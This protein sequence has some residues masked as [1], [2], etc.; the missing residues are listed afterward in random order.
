MR[1][2]ITDDTSISRK[3]LQAVF[4][5]LANDRKLEILGYVAGREEVT[6]SE[7]K[8]ELG[9][10]HTTAHEYCR[11]LHATGF[12]VRKGGKPARYAPA[13]FDLQ[14]SLSSI[15]DAVESESETLEYTIETYGEGSIDDVID[16]WERVEAGELTYREASEEV[17]M[18]HVDFLR[19]AQEL[20]LLTR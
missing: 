11:D 2:S 18:A 8:D 15:A 10:P 20:E 16:V 4:E 5:Q 19:V 9:L 14:L 6:V 7:L 17:G 12:L 1:M 3:R 13:D